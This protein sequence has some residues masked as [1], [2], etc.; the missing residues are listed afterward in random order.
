MMH[1]VARLQ[2]M[3]IFRLWKRWEDLTILKNELQYFWAK[4][5]ARWGKRS[6]RSFI[7]SWHAY[8]Q[9]IKSA[10]AKLVLATRH[11]ERADFRKATLPVLK[12]WRQRHLEAKPI[13]RKHGR[14]LMEDR[15]FRIKARPIR[16]RMFGQMG[17]DLI[18]FW[19]NYTKAKERERRLEM[20]M[21]GM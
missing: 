17:K 21:S 6:T 13:W 12:D 18:T 20:M 11:S 14:R 2:M 3:D 5:I 7:S 9:D 19:I 1:V 16:K 15:P 10:K 8:T 4:A